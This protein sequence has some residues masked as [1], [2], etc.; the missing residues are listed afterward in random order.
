VQRWNGWGDDST[1]YPL[2]EPAREYL[3]GIVGSGSTAADAPIEQLL[4]VVPASRLPEDPLLTLEAKARLL[5]ACGQSLPDWVGLHA[6]RLP[7]FP[8]AVAYART[9][10]DVRAVLAFCRRSGAALIPYGGG[11]SVV[12]HINPLPGGPPTVTLD[13]S[14]MQ[15]LLSLNETN[16]LAVFEAGVRGPDLEERLAA[17]GFT[18]GHFPQSFEYSTLGG[19]IATR[20]CGQQ[21]FYY[22]RIEDLFAGGHV[23]TPAGAIDLPELPASAA[24]PDLRHLL[25]GSE[26]RLGVITRASV[27]VRRRPETEGFYGVFFHDWASGA[28]AVRQI[29][30][31]G[32]AVSM[33]R[34]SDAQETETTLMLAAKPDLTRWADRG[35]R[36]A[37]YRGERSLL[38]LGITGEHRRARETLRHAMAICRRHGGL[39]PIAMIGRM[40]Q[41]SRFLSPYLRNTLWS[42]GYALDTVETAL[43][44]SRA[45]PAAH[46]IQQTLRGAFE[47]QGERLLVFTHLSH[48]YT[49]GASVYTTFL[50]RRADD[51][52]Q[53]VATWHLAKQA[54]SRAIVQLGGT[55]SHQHG[56]GLDHAP[57]LEAEKGRTGI[58]L[59]RAACRALD[60]D[61]MLN[62][63]KLVPAECG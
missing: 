42:C 5:H 23:E 61:G 56:V 53:T 18:L 59:L 49:D 29:A 37:G 38:I 50:F 2:P 33:L 36:L 11:T 28:E 24:G 44:W 34:L 3:A 51:P 32:L 27:R 48:V 22:G 8:D 52:D 10:E 17:R 39:F 20:S 25:L 19:W 6:G 4:A 26:G 1:D 13:L 57:F 9:E 12:G 54:V 46:T 58:A 14:P 35:L 40:W 60:P 55:I 15:R 7:A 41:K 21:S 45:L 63:G 62:P 30:Q 31:S 47:A 16:S 43:P